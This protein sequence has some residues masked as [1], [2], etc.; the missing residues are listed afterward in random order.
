MKKG[1]TL[2]ELLVVV[3]IIG[4]LASIVLVSVNS[5]RAKARDVKRMSDLHNVQLALEMYYDKYNT[6]LVAGTGWSGCG[7]GYLAFEGGTYAKAVTR[8]LQEEGFLSVP[9]VEDPIQ[10][11]GYM[12]YLCENS[13]VYAISARKE[14]PT[15]DDISYI[16]RTCNGTGINGTYT[17]YGKNYAVSNKTY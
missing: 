7:C 1:F 15:T 17:V 10:N 16:Q 14:N 6:Y 5:A 2:I 4:L 9:I 3:A 11:P 13:Q 12:I 8:G